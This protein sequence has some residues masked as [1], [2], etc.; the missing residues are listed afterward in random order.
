MFDLFFLVD[1]WFG[2]QNRKWET[3]KEKQFGRKKIG[4]GPA[5]PAKPNKAQNQPSFLYPERKR[6]TLDFEPTEKLTGGPSPHSI[7]H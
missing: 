7:S 1:L 6:F 4:S 5:Q 3:E 2:F